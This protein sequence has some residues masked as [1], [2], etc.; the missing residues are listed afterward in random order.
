[1]SVLSDRIREGREYLNFPPELMAERVGIAA[2]DYAAFE[3]GEREPSAPVLA[4]LAW[5]CGTT[6]ERLR[7]EDLRAD[8]DIE[9]AIANGLMTHDD[10]YEVHRFAEF[11]RVRA[12]DQP[13]G[14]SR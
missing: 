13:S 7:G 11:L 12:T 6:L 1:M 3:T 4:R 5:L 2:S 10:A 9:E 14:E 8:P